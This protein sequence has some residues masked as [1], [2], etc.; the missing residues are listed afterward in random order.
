MHKRPWRSG[1]PQKNSVPSRASSPS[2][3]D[4]LTNLLYIA[5][6]QLPVYCFREYLA[7]AVYE[8]AVSKRIT[9][10]PIHE[11]SR[12]IAQI[13]VHAVDTPNWHRRAAGLALNVVVARAA[14][15]PFELRNAGRS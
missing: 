1:T 7:R 6:Y 9:L 4:R 8:G 11:P 2:I 15:G 3:V 14:E 5:C 13:S 12:R 10:Q